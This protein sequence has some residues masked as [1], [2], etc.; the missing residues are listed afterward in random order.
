MWFGFYRGGKASAALA[1]ATGYAKHV[2]AVFAQVNLIFLVILLSSYSSSN[3]TS[4]MKD[5]DAAALG[6]V[7]LFLGFYS[8]GVS[9]SRVPPFQRRMSGRHGTGERV[10]ILAP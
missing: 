9:S 5:N 1:K 4:Y 8:K 2:S 3:G 10:R 7:Q 6:A